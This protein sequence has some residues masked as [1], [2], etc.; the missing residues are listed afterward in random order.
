MIEQLFCILIVT[1]CVQRAGYMHPTAPLIDKIALS[2]LGGAVVAYLAEV[3]VHGAAH[4]STLLLLIGVALWVIPPSL[5]CW[6]GDK[7]VPR[8]VG[9]VI[10]R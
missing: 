1:W 4:E 6:L 7:Q 10:G 9:A 8:I 5:R 2:W 3:R